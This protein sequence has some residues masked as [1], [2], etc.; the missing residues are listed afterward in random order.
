MATARASAACGTPTFTG[1]I[2]AQPRLELSEEAN[3]SGVDGRAYSSPP[4]S[5]VCCFP[6]KEQAD[7]L[8]AL[9]KAHGL[10]AV[11]IGAGDGFAEAQLE[12]RGV[13]VEA[14]DLDVFADAS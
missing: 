14:V 8:A 5:T 2:F 6:T 11:S 3:S 10:H 1:R 12:E 13:S 4:S 7:A 9:L